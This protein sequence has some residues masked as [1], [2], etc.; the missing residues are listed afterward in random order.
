MRIG[1]IPQTVLEWFLSKMNVIPFP[2]EDTFVAMMQTRAIMAANRLGIFT[3]LA[4]GPASSAELAR[5]LSCQI[6][7]LEALLEAVK[8]AGYVVEQKGRYSLSPKARKWVT[9]DSS[10]SV[11]WFIEFN[12][13]NWERMGNL[14]ESVKTGKSL[15]LHAQLLDI[16]QWRRYLYGLHDL[17]RMA[18]KEIVLRRLVGS[19]PKLLLDIG[20]GHGGYSAAFCRAYPLLKAVIFDLPQ[21]I[22]I[23]NEI[24]RKHYGDVTD[25]I[26]FKEGDITKDSWGTGYDVVLLMNVIHH[27]EPE[28]IRQIFGKIMGTI[29]P[30]GVLL[31]LDQLNNVNKST[32]YLASMAELLFLVMTSGR[33]YRF[34]TVQDWLIEAGFKN[35]RL[36][37]LRVGPGASVLAAEKS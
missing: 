31:I 19:S 26:E 23:G 4:K 29:K 34:D 9:P 1:M 7:G 10:E 18:A 2:A 20:G 32:A 30:G 14:E 33:S 35:I 24:I 21:A 5:D 25:R 12:Y 22:E 16:T 17:S 8:N 27:F 3:S 15:D 36:K 13:D 6:R 37:N 28:Q 11:N